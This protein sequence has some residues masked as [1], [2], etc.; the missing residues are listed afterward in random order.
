LIHANSG[1]YEVALLSCPYLGAEVE[2]SEERERHISAHHPD[3]LPAHRSRIEETIAD[4]DMIRRSNR[5]GNARL[6]TKW[7][8]DIRG[9]RFVIVVVVHD[10]GLEKRPWIITAYL[11]RKLKEGE[12]EWERN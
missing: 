12:I 6:F 2:L 10:P 9:G 1:V 8:A 7:F 11:S 3:L 4:P 5:V